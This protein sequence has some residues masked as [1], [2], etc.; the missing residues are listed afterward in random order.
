MPIAS[1]RYLFTAWSISGAPPDA[2]VYVLWEADELIYVGRALGGE[3]TIQSRL[4]EHY[5][6]HARP[7]DATHY[8]WELSRDAAAREAELLREFEAAFHRLPRGNQAA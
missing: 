8:G 6:R 1:P 7:W 3:A 2:G 5:T 4:R